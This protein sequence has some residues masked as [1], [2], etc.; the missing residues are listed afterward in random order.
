VGSLPTEIDSPRL[1]V[2]TRTPPPTPARVDEIN[3]PKSDFRYE[4]K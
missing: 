3:R 1:Y 4:L 2:G